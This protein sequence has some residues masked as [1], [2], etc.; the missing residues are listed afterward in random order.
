MPEAL[1]AAEIPGLPG[2][3]HVR[4]A[5]AS[6]NLDPEGAVLKVL[7][8]RRVPS[9]FGAGGGALPGW[10][11]GLHEAHGPALATVLPFLP[12]VTASPAAT[13][14]TSHEGLILGLREVLRAWP[15]PHQATWVAGAPCSRGQ[16]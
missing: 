9:P 1:W 13:A 14:G 7:C 16:S 3:A 10:G 2:L 5:G 6:L 15:H 11:G 8:P 4:E 12:L